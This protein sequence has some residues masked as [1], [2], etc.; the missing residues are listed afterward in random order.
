VEAAKVL[1]RSANEV[2]S[3]NLVGEIG[4]LNSAYT[5]NRFGVSQNISFPF[6]NAKRKEWFQKQAEMAQMNYKFS[7]NAIKKKLRKLFTI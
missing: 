6:V 5:D 3:L 4:Q 2:P 1:I 7:E